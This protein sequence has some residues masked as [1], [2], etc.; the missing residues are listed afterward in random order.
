M[1]PHLD[2]LAAYNAWANERLYAAV[3]RLPAADYRADRGVFFGS[4]HGTLN[5]ILIGDRIWMHVF[6]GEGT[7][8]TQLDAILHEDL[9]G[10]REAR[11]AEDARIG[12][13]VGS[14]TEEALA[15]TVRYSTIRSPADI[16]QRLAPL[17]LHFFNHQTHHRGQ[18]HGLLTMSCGEAPSLDMVMFQRETGVSL[19]SGAGGVF[20]RAERRTARAPGTA[21]AAPRARVPAAS[22][23]G[24]T[25]GYSRAVRAGDL[26]FVAGTTASGPQGTFHPGDAAG[27]AK[28]VIERIA[29]AL[30]ELGA[31]LADVVETRIFLTDIADWR[32][33]GRV[34]GLVFGDA[35]PATTMVQIGP[36]MSPDLRVEI[37]A[38]AARPAS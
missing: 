6:T 38:V 3:A 19:V 16:E 23:L 21:S 27:Q 36:L 30:R 5:H 32:E 37:S 31:E 29:A 25:I 14:L 10:L 4:L 18:A 13:Y 9:A 33:V 20:S 35:R 2:M 34:H 8:P 24:E 1:K 28:V 15:G 11:R 17:L 7:K 26:V 12:R 22:P